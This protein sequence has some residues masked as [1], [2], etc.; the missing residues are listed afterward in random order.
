MVFLTLAAMPLAGRAET[1]FGRKDDGRI[2]VDEIAGFLVATALVRP[3]WGSVILGFIFFR[4][5]DILKPWPVRVIDRRG[6]GGPGVVLDDV[7]AGVYACLCLLF[8]AYLWPWLGQ[9]V[10]K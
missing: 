1:L 8:A 6:A 4:F 7:L 5:F 2:V 9:A 3:A 10:W